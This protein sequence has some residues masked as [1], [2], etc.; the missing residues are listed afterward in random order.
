VTCE[1]NELSDERWEGRV[2]VGACLNDKT[3]TIKLL[4]PVGLIEVALSATKWKCVSPSSTNAKTG[5][6]SDKVRLNRWSPLFFVLMLHTD[7]HTLP[8]PHEHP[9]AVLSQIDVACL[10]ARV[11]LVLFVGRKMCAFRRNTTDGGVLAGWPRRW[12]SRLLSNDIFECTNGQK[13]P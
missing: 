1:N 6:K 7:N 8:S 2:L 10:P 9:R 11:G 12:E 3:T 13:V 5:S 4:E